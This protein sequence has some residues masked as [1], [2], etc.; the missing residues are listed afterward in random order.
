M[1][2][3]LQGASTML[4]VGFFALM[5]IIGLPLLFLLNEFGEFGILALVPIAAF[6]LIIVGLIRL[7]NVFKDLVNAAEG[8]VPQAEVTRTASLQ[9]PV[10][11]ATVKAFGA[12]QNAAGYWEAQAM[13]IDSKRDISKPRKQAAAPKESW[14]ASIDWEEWV[15][16]KLLQKAGILIV[17]IGMLVFLKYSFDNGWVDELGRVILSCMGAAALLVAGELF[18]AKYSKWSHAFTGGGLVLMYITVWVAHVLYASALATKYGIVLPAGM[19]FI[20]YSFITLVGALAAVRYKAQTIAWFTVLGGYL[21]PF[22]VNASTPDHTA[23][24]LYLAILAGGMILLAWHT[25]W[26]HINTAAFLFTNFYLF[27][28]IYTAVPEFGD[29]A[30]VITAAGFFLL[31]NI[32]PLLYQ[33]RQKL[34]ADQED[35][36]L[37]VL[38]AGA[39]FLPVVD[40]VGGWDSGYVGLICLILAAFYMVFS[41][42]ALKN[43]GEDGTLVNTYLVGTVI[44]VAGA[45]FAE[46][47]A[48]WVAAGWAPLS[49]LLMYIATRLQRKGPWVCSVIVLLGSL[50]FL[51]INMP[52]FTA[53]PEEIWY[54]FT[55]NWAIQSYVV[56]ASL[57]G[58]IVLSKRLPEQLITRDRASFVNLLHVAL[59][60][61]LFMAVTFE[62]TRLNFTV[63]L[64]WTFAYVALAVV[65][66]A[67]FFFTESIVWFAAAFMVQLLALLFIFMFGDTSGLS[68]GHTDAVMPFLHPWSYLSVAALLATVSMVY[69]AQL[70]RDR[71]TAGLPAHLLLIAVALAQIWVH[72]SVEIANIREAYDWS[73]L[74]YDRVLTAWWIIFA[75]AVFAYG[76]LKNLRGVCHA[77]VLLLLI[78]YVH[79]HLSILGGEERLTET[80]IWT[81][82][83][84]GVCINA[85]RLKDKRMLT[86]GMMMIGFGAGIDMVSHLGNSG[87]GLVRSS[88]WA[89]AGLATMVTGFMEKEQYLRKLAMLIFGATALKLL[90]IDFSSLETPVRIFASIATGLLMIGASYLYQRFDAAARTGVASPK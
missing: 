47:K 86:I 69:M 12:Q 7:R 60:G 11:K 10:P 71:F 57:V 44:L 24:L 78:P 13:A 20:L 84:L 46:L 17:L 26:K 15:G 3:R 19:A 2:R 30:Q 5:L 80:M 8:Q 36:M 18:H 51:G 1:Y 58:W 9:T 59:A 14:S 31:F 55:S 53:G 73:Y 74:S 79:N 66:M 40:A 62:A 87:A 48:E 39:V 34:K 52:V 37:I 27:T 89:L 54:P 38:N 45:L 82:I 29:V 63:D 41:G 25:K 6:L 76:R 21:T 50:F 70:K 64:V 88:W 32:L 49:L 16:Q 65:C 35:I 68:I 43:R 33:F 22:L 56:F 85:A 77:G 83:S 23:L 28:A 61:I 4:V 67:A 81:V 72:V 90:L 42:M 75:L